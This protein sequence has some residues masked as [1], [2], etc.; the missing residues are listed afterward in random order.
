MDINLFKNILMITSEMFGKS[1]ISKLIC[2]IWSLQYCKNFERVVVLDLLIGLKWQGPWWICVVTW[3]MVWRNSYHRRAVIT[4]FRYM[5]ICVNFKCVNFSWLYIFICKYRYD[6]DNYVLND[7]TEYPI[8]TKCFHFK[9]IKCGKG[10]LLYQLQAV[11]I[12]I[13]SPCFSFS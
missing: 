7:W 9:I 6:V 3:S 10:V 4:V 12:S 5:Y 8:N 2:V 1:R 11:I 13:G